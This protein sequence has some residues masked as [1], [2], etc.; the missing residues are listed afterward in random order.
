MLLII[1]NIINKQSPWMLSLEIFDSVCAAAA[2]SRQIRYRPPIPAATSKDLYKNEY[3]NT[4][5]FF[6]N[7]HQISCSDFF[8][9]IFHFLYIFKTNW[10]EL[11]GRICR[12][13]FTLF[14]PCDVTGLFMSTQFLLG[15]S[16]HLLSLVYILWG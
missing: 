7:S 10:T 11:I 9:H 3:N 5:Q 1:S 4:S 2:D 14:R 12:C 6:T 13:L 16:L 8:F 15:F